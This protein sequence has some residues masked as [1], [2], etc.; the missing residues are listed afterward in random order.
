MRRWPF[1]ILVLFLLIGCNNNQDPH[2]TTNDDV[3]EI[4]EVSFKTSPE[5]VRVNQE[6]QLIAIISQGEELV[7][8][9]SLVEFEIWKD[10]Q[11]KDQHEKIEANNKK[12]GEY[13]A[14][15]SFKET[16]KY[17]IISHTTARD[18]HLSLIHI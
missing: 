3:P 1:I 17:F 12:N 7:D 6:V 5:S 8:D 14:F 13:T 16:G 11:S 9:A 2:N 18:L 10:G 4:V 15:Y